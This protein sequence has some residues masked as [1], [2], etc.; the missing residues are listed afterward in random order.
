[1]AQKA[2]ALLQ[3]IKPPV[4]LPILTVGTPNRQV[5]QN[6][7]ATTHNPASTKTRAATPT[8][9]GREATITRIHQGAP[10]MVV[11]EEAMA[12]IAVMVE[13]VLATEEDT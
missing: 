5:K 4:A 7:Q 8:S 6:L 11:V 12:V 1:M 3:S 13:V 10:H 2:E 9:Q